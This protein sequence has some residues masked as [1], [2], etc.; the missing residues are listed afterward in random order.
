MAITKINTVVL[1][2]N[3]DKARISEGR[4]CTISILKK[5]FL[6]VVRRAKKY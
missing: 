5:K 3:F 2:E 6:T 4:L 1:N